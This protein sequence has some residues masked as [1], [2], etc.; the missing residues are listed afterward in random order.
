MAKLVDSYM[1]KANLSLKTNTYIQIILFSQ[2]N[3][4]SPSQAAIALWPHNSFFM[5]TTEG[6]IFLT[7]SD[8]KECRVGE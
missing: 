5:Q 8:S 6:T 2:L 3:I 7:N 4:F 1:F